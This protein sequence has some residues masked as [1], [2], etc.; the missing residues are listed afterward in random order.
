[1]KSLSIVRVKPLVHVAGPISHVYITV[2]EAGRFVEEIEDRRTAEVKPQELGV[3]SYDICR[4][5]SHTGECE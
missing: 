4:C 5:S 1:M 2:L 3:R